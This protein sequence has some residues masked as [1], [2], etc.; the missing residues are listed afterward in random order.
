KVLELE[1]KMRQAFVACMKKH[2]PAKG[3]CQ[4]DNPFP[5]T[6]AKDWNFEP[7]YRGNNPSAA[8]DAFEK[9]PSKLDCYSMGNFWAWV[10][11]R[12][13]LTAE[14]FD[15]LFKGKKIVITQSLRGYYPL[16]GRRV[17]ANTLLSPLIENKIGPKAMGDILPGDFVQFFNTPGKPGKLGPW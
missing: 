9:G 16:A 7:S 5:S 10:A 14:K 12:D 1:L 8:L 6:K 3:G 15:E 11:L 4:Y 13:A 17:I 2:A